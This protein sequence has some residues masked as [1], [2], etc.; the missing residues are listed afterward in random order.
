MDRDLDQAAYRE[1]VQLAKRLAVSVE[2]GDD[3]LMW[4]TAYAIKDWAEVR[5][6]VLFWAVFRD[7]DGHRDFLDGWWLQDDED[8]MIHFERD[9]DEWDLRA[10][11]TLLFY[12]NY[13]HRSLGE[14]L[15]T[16]PV[17]PEAGPTSAAVLVNWKN[18]GF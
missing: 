1:L 2:T 9:R 12:K 4:D 8:V 18:E 13:R 5:G 6:L 11:D 7:R 3:S 15:F 17:E 16:M 10:G 14:P